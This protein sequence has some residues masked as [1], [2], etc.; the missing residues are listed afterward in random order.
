MRAIVIPAYGGP[1]VLKLTDLPV[2]QPGEG[3]VLVKVEAIG[4]NP[5]DGKWR[6]GRYQ[7]F[8]P[9]PMPHVLGYDVA[10]TVVS[11]EGFAAGTRV[12][13]ML[14][15]FTKGG[16][17][18]FAVVSAASIATIPD[19]MSFATAAAIPCANLTGLQLVET[20]LQPAAGQRVLITGALGN[21]GR[22]ALFA[23]ARRGVHI[24]AA[25]R[26][27]RAEE[28][29]AAGAAEVAAIGEDWTGEPFDH[30]IDTIGG[31]DV[32]PLMRHLRPG[33]RIVTASD[34]PI[35]ADDLPATPEFD[36]VI[37][38]GAQLAELVRAVASGALPVPVG[39]VLPLEQAAEAQQAVA[40]GGNR[41]KIILQP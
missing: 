16:Y 7:A 2:P 1:E 11:G 32:A 39:K 36:G 9:V 23:A 35:P 6:E 31:A 25:V 33:G 5:A 13:A 24:I 17:A 37:P 8:A 19:D 10:G 40:A 20:R 14:H 28:A 29:L 3:E 41:G 30:A 4:V 21:V 15:P 22:S 18:E 38:D 27:D 26:A 34:V 12:A